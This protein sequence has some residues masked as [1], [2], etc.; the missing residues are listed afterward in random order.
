M[1]HRTFRLVHSVV[2]A[3]PGARELAAS[4]EAL[5]R[6]YAPLGSAGSHAQEVPGG[7]V[8]WVAFDA[9]EHLRLR[10]QAESGCLTWGEAAATGSGA[11]LDWSGGRLRTSAGDG[12]PTALYRC[13]DA[14]A[15]HAVAAAWMARGRRPRVRFDLVP[16]LVLHEFVLGSET[17]VDGVA[18]VVP[19]SAW[20]EVAE[21]DA[22]ASGLAAL[23]ETLQERLRSSSAPALGLTGGL[24]SRVVAAALSHLGIEA[25]TFTWSHHAEDAAGA[26][27]VAARLGLG[28]RRCPPEF[29]PDAAGLAQ[30]RAD[31]RWS[32][33]QARLTP[34]GRVTWPE[35]MTSFVTGGGGEVGRAFYYRLEAANHRDPDVR[36][37]VR[38]M[39]VG[40]RLASAPQDVVRHLEERLG[41]EL[42]ALAGE[43]WRRLDVF[44]AQRRLAR[45]GRAMLGRS[46]VPTVAAFATPAVAASLIGMS[47]RERTSD[48]FHRYALRELGAEDLLPPPST[49]QRGAVPRPVRRVVATLRRRRARGEPAL[50]PY[51]EELAARPL[52]AQW[53]DGALS[54]PSL[55]GAL[56]VEWVQA[57]RAGVASGHDAPVMTALLATA[58]VALEQ[59]LR[60]LPAAL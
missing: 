16:E 8:G 46:G 6:F 50:W 53:L 10:R 42:N 59:A 60:D 14:V 11:R 58:P 21:E 3:L 40:E 51:F 7:V 47:E 20:P 32:E 18:P 43:G 45:W 28:H 23:L 35:G 56:G 39:R 37:L 29:L 12:L 44:Y 13:D 41:R 49:G 55:E 34:F 9:R 36:R 38:L 54:A 57:L 33:G 15:T 2:F 26:A 30:L 31:V 52:Y 4:V 19:Q 22:P 25:D 24:D 27:A 17:I 48:G 1:S 5:A